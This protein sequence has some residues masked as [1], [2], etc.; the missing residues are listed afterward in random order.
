MRRAPATERG[1]RP[2]RS[3]RSLWNKRSRFEI[4][5]A[6]RCAC[7]G[8]GSQGSRRPIAAHTAVEGRTTAPPDIIF[9]RRYFL[10][11]YSPVRST[12]SGSEM[13]ARVNCTLGGSATIHLT[14]DFKRPTLWMKVKRYFIGDVVNHVVVVHWNLVITVSCFILAI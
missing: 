10:L 12:D 4:W 14:T 6:R 7:G 8:G 5:K 9:L 3:A 2:A 11:S 13:N 1:A